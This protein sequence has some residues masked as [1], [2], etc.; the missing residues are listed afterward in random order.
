MRTRRSGIARQT[1]AVSAVALVLAA[2][3]ALE[4]SQL[5][6]I[7]SR[8]ASTTTET[9]TVTVTSSVSPAASA[10]L[11]FHQEGS[12]CGFM[13]SPWG[14]TVR[15]QTWNSTE[16]QPPNGLHEIQ[17]MMPGEGAGTIYNASMAAI[18][19]LLTAGV[20]D[21]TMIPA[22]VGGSNASGTVTMRG[23]DV[24]IQFPSDFCPP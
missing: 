13:H 11:I 8:P 20:Y 23:V 19:F 6:S 24:A 21:Y 16:V 7:G 14:V 5:Q 1:V 10:F 17:S 9:E 4:Y 12:P 3:A 22:G 18:V 2:A 15:N